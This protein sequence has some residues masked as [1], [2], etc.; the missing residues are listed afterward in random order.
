[1]ALVSVLVLVTACTAGHGP[2]IQLA[3]PPAPA[4]DFGD[5][6][7]EPQGPGAPGGSSR[8]SELSGNAS[9]SR[10]SP[11]T[12]VGVVLGVAAGTTALVTGLATGAVTCKPGVDSTGA[13]D[14]GASMNLCSGERKPASPDVERAFRPGGSSR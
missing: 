4:P 11:A 8:G 12:T 14:A 1:M 2:H 13:S 5:V 6:S 9:A 7:T 10:S 3:T